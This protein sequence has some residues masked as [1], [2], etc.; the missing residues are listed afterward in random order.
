MNADTLAKIEVFG[1]GLIKCV[2]RLVTVVSILYTFFWMFFYSTYFANL[3]FII[4]LRNWYQNTYWKTESLVFKPFR[5]YPPFN[6]VYTISV[7]KSDVKGTYKYSLWGT[8]SSVDTNNKA[9]YI[10]GSDGKEYVFAL[11]SYGFIFIGPVSKDFGLVGITTFKGAKILAEWQDTRSL[12]TIKKVYG[13][14]RIA[15]INQSAV[16]GSLPLLSRQRFRH[17]IIFQISCTLV[18]DDVFKRNIIHAAAFEA[19]HHAALAFQQTLDG[20]KTHA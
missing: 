3:S 17:L 16:E 8:V 18:A 6:P 15:P 7:D 19:G 14:N 9:I 11:S 12:G 2:I 1:W 4:P 10:L 20:H 5:I 13:Q